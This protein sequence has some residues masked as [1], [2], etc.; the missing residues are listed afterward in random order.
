MFDENAG[1]FLE[2]WQQ[3]IQEFNSHDNNFRNFNIGKRYNKMSRKNSNWKEEK[4][5][6]EKRIRLVSGEVEVDMS[7][8][9]HAT[10]KREFRFFRKKILTIFSLRK[11]R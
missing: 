11:M 3:A 10:K 2:V 7:S 9:Y 1:G 6:D 8:Y 5:Y 4:G